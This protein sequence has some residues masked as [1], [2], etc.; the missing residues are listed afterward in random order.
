MT[1][2]TPDPRCDLNVGLFALK[3]LCKA[4]C[5]LMKSALFVHVYRILLH[6][7]MY[8]YDIYVCFC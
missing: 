6:F 3:A 8:V 1:C 2:S 7:S 4:K 5:V